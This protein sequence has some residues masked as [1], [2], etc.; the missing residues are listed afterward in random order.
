MKSLLPIVRP[1]VGFSISESL[2]LNDSKNIEKGFK[3]IEKEN[4][5]IAEFIHRWS[6]KIIGDATAHSAFC[7]IL[8][9][10]LLKSQAEADKMNKELRLG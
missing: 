5:I 9:Y 4:P 8:V 10:K 3:E 6:N 2:E 7:G 1:E